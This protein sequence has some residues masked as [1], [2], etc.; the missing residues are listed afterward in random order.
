MFKSFVYVI[1][2]T[3][4]FANNLPQDP[5]RRIIP[6]SLVF[7]FKNVITLQLNHLTQFKVNSNAVDPFLT[8]SGDFS[9]IQKWI[10]R[11]QVIDGLNQ[12]IQL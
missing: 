1:P 4:E 2:N 11:I 5:P 8:S 9:G 3:V 12:S 7:S 10:S 6:F